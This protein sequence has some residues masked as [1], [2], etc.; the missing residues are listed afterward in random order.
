MSLKYLSIGHNNITNDGFK[1]L[2]NMLK[3]NKS[4]IY[5]SL[6]SSV[7]DTDVSI[8]FETQ[9]HHNKTLK[10]L[11]FRRSIIR[12]DRVLKSFMAVIKSGSITH[13]DLRDCQIGSLGGCGIEDAFKQ[14]QS[15]V[16][17]GLEGN[18]LGSKEA[19]K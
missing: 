11:N 8:K 6:E 18:R 5:L 16:Y 13:L 2:V 15:F 3:E 4:L 10:Y 1:E 19:E 17:L 9:L 14:N 12:G 7:I